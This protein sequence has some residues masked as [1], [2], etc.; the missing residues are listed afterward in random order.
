MS[1]CT[2]HCDECVGHI[3]PNGWYNNTITSET[4]SL[5]DD[6][7][8]TFNLKL[9]PSLEKLTQLYLYNDNKTS[10]VT[11]QCNSDAQCND[12]Q[13]C[14]GADI[15]SFVDE[16]PFSCCTGYRSCYQATS[17]SGGGGAGK[18]HIFCDGVLSCDSS[19]LMSVNEYYDGGMLFCRSSQ[20]CASD[21]ILI[22][23]NSGIWSSGHI[24][25]WQVGASSLFTPVTAVDTSSNTSLYCLAS[26]SCRNLIVNNIKYIYDF[27]KHSLEK[28]TINSNNSEYN[29]HE[30]HI[31]KLGYGRDYDF[32]INCHENDTCYYYCDNHDMCNAV[33]R[34]DGLSVCP[35]CTVVR[36]YQHNICENTTAPTRLPTII[37]TEIPS[38]IP[39]E[40]LTTQASP[41][42]QPTNLPTVNM[43]NTVV[44]LNSTTL[45][46]EM[47]AT[48][49]TTEFELSSVSESESIEKT[50][51]QG[52]GDESSNTNDINLFEL[53]GDSM[54]QVLIIFVCGII[55]GCICLVIPLCCCWATRKRKKHGADDVTKSLQ[56]VGTSSP[57][58]PAGLTNYDDRY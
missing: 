33:L 15:P 31:Y 27:G 34:T 51:D 46:E 49:N 22:Y 11:G 2:V 43:I 45:L 13:E 23:G 16:P 57:R 4:A 5:M 14:V 9:P 29:N 50:T 25:I 21:S 30:L 54:I 10:A 28:S 3:C 18:G 36:L 44:T 17:I 47:S 41:T 56:M 20:A 1:S 19:N 32:E 12:Y 42:Y 53:S 35:N 6:I 7:F 58:S 48:A 39:S 38:K 52:C 37:P 8:P 24:A 40:I 26:G 55:T